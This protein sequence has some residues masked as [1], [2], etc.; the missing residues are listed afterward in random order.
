[1]AFFR[2]GA[3]MCLRAWLMPGMT[4]M[5]VFATTRALGERLT[6]EGEQPEQYRWTDGSDSSVMAHFHGG[7]L[8][9]WDLARPAPEAETAP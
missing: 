4:L 8:V 1:M 9:S 3:F 7:R 2:V 6:P 5:Y